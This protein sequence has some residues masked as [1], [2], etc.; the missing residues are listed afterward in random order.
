MK[1]VVVYK[2]DSE[3]ARSVTEWLRD[4]ERRTGKHIDEL[5]P[6]TREGTSFCR[7]YDIVE[8]P[9]LVALDDNGVIQNLWRGTMLPTISEVSYYAQ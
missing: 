5:D 1:V 4:F 2:P 8:Y 6:D 9:T 7:S 3:Y